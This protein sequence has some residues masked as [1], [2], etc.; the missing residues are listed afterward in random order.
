[1]A[2]YT[3]TDNPGSTGSMR[4]D[5]L[6]LI[7][8]I[9]PKDRPLTAGLKT[10]RTAMNT[11]HEWLTDSLASRGSLATVEGA[12]ASYG[13]ETA[14]TRAYN[15]V[16]QIERPWAISDVLIA[17]RHAG[18]SNPEAYTIA[19]AS[20]EWANALEYDVIQGTRT[21]FVEATTAA[22]MGGVEAFI[23]TEEKDAGS[24]PLDEK[25]FNDLASDVFDNGG[26]PTE[27]FC[28]GNLKRQISSW[29]VN[30]R[31]IQAEDKRLARSVDVYIGDFETV[32]VMISRDVSSG[33]LLLID[34]KLW[35][36]AYLIN[37]HKEDRAK[38]GSAT[39]GVL[40]GNVT[41]E[42]LQEAGNGEMTSLST[43][44]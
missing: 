13:A 17:T 43:T 24:Q 27:V 42:S 31:N 20:A 28:R 26:S 8:N 4:E 33:T 41:L 30:T 29:S 38:T 37:P 25:I 21:A 44:I 23:S 3:S 5:L 6:D 1:M 9:S 2:L 22:V 32:K 19:K 11:K 16:E 40:I 39:K 15:Y 34:P 35:A 36:L 12:D 18:M 10:K 14:P 7:T